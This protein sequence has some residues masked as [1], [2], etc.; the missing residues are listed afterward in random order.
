MEAHGAYLRGVDAVELAPQPQTEEEGA[1]VSTEEP[2]VT[3]WQAAIDR[4]ERLGGGPGILLKL[5]R[6]RDD[7]ASR[8]EAGRLD[9]AEARRLLE[10]ALH[11][12]QH[13]E[14]APGGTETW[15]EFDRKAEHF[16]RWGA[17]GADVPQALF[18]QDAGPE[19]E[20]PGDCAWP[21]RACTG[22]VAA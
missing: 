3:E 14:N 5:E 21:E 18:G 9:A 10:Y 2:S 19:W 13:G 17:G 8:I 15:A 1:Q 6:E 16:L 4:G 20:H 22:H 7:L 12:R 11:L